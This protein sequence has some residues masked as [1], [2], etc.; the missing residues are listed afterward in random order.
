MWRPEENLF[1][2][3]ASCKSGT[4]HF[5]GHTLKNNHQPHTPEKK[6]GNWVGHLSLP[7]EWCRSPKWLEVK[8]TVLFGIV[9]FLSV[10]CFGFL[11]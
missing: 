11:Q 10:G 7:A 9:Y 8:R 6:A 1:R 4:D 2:T 3:V 5:S